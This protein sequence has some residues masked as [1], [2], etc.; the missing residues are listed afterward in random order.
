[1]PSLTSHGPHTV[2]VLGDAGID[3][4][5]SVAPRVYP[6]V[7]YRARSADEFRAM[8]TEAPSIDGR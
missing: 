8:A 3:P 6:G 1:M 4:D 7:T 2:L 5:S